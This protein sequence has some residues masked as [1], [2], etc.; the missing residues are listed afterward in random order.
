MWVGVVGEARATA[1]AL[2]E[3][4]VG[5]GRAGRGRGVERGWIGEVNE[6]LWVAVGPVHV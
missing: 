6:V 3:V 1:G 5:M 4:Y 2:R